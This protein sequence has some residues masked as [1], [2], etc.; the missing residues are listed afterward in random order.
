MSATSLEHLDD[1]IAGVMSRE[2]QVWLVN[3]ISSRL[4]KT[5]EPL[6]P[7]TMKELDAQ[8]DEAEA[9]FAA[10]EYVSAEDHRRVMEKHIAQYYVAAV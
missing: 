5:K 1:Y 6:T 3:R 8:L 7:Y 9:Q 2:D 4:V 10:G